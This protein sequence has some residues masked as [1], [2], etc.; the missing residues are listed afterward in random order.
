[1]RHISPTHRHKCNLITLPPTTAPLLINISGYGF[2][3]QVSHDYF[4]DGM[5]RGRS[6]L[7]IFQYTLSGKGAVSLCGMEHNVH[8]GMAML[9]EVPQVHQ[10]YL[11]HDAEYWEFIWVNLVGYEAMRVWRQLTK[12]TGPVAVLPVQ[13]EAVDEAITFIKSRKQHKMLNPHENSIM[14]YSFL[15]KLIK[16]L[17]PGK[18]AEK[19]PD[20]IQKVIAYCLNNI[21]EP[22]TVEDLA[23][24]SGYSRYHFNRIFKEHQGITPMAFMTQIRM[25]HALG[26]LQSTHLNIK[27]ISTQC[28]FEDSSYFCKVFR[29]HYNV[30]PNR[31]RSQS[32]MK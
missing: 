16:E 22:L 1:M 32:G 27:E 28:G 26:L 15:M 2:E 6:P 23:E 9:V 12:K 11:P 20:F 19:K 30:S 17:L 5:T 14:A 18:S 8:P 3:K 10:Y 13:S 25:N 7:A 31:F 21:H 24:K 29:K 4:W